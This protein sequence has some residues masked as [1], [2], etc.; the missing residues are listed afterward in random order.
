MV[1]YTVFS[2]S[3]PPGVPP[4]LPLP[5]G[6]LQQSVVMV[7]SMV[8]RKKLKNLQHRKIIIYRINVL[9]AY[10]S[11]SSIKIQ[12]K[13]DYIKHRWYFSFLHVNKAISSKQKLKWS[14]NIHTIYLWSDLGYTLTVYLLLSFNAVSETTNTFHNVLTMY[15]HIRL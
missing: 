1:L 11:F 2:P 13:L 12:K 7:C 5:T 9:H 6:L 4:T 14:F 8:S 15:S 10:E 3:Q